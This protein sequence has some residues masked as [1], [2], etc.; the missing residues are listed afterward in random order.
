MH[1]KKKK[2]T[3]S[4][5]AKVCNIKE[6]H[7]KFLN[8]YTLCNHAFIVP[9]YVN[10]QINRFFKDFCCEKRSSNVMAFEKT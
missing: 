9:D 2:P 1:Y 5:A 4:I 6:Y 3:L 7:F 10:T 8:V